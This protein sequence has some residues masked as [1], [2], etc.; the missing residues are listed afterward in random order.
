GGITRTSS[1]RFVSDISSLPSC[2]EDSHD[3]ALLLP[4]LVRAPALLQQRQEELRHTFVDLHQRRTRSEGLESLERA[5]HR[6]R[7]L[8]PAHIQNEDVISGRD[9]CG[10]FGLLR[11]ARVRGGRSG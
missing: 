5:R 11:P 3:V 4:Y 10:D 9:C 6:L 7:R 1:V 2:N 8:Q